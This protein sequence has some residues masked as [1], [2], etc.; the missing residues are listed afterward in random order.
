[1]R[2]SLHLLFTRTSTCTHTRFQ[3][4]SIYICSCSIFARQNCLGW[5]N[6]I[7]SELS[8]TRTVNK[9]RARLPWIVVAAALL[10]LIVIIMEM[11]LQLLKTYNIQENWFETFLQNVDCVPTPRPSA[12]THTYVQTYSAFKNLVRSPPIWSAR[13]FVV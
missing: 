12:H 1:M 5:A 11:H 13:Y 2:N 8:G 3:P 10:F 4:Y 7:Q 9:L 6:G